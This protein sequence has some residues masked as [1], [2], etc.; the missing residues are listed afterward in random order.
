MDVGLSDTPDDPYDT[1]TPDGTDLS[2]RK[3]LRNIEIAH[4]FLP[5]P[6]PAWRM[7]ES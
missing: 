4:F 7:N 6:A 3:L 2:R 5:G 1:G